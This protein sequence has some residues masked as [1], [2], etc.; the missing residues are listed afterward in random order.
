MRYTGPLIAIKDTEKSN[1]FYHDALGPFVAQGLSPEQ[2]AIR[3]NI[4]LESVVK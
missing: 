4:P 1:G 3:M 2:I